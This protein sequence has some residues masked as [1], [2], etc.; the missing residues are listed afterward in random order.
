MNPKSKPPRSKRSKLKCEVL[1]STSAF[2]FNL[3]RYNVA[4]SGGGGRRGLLFGDAKVGRCR[5][6]LS[7]PR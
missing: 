2:N 4:E 1:L 7:N 6:T 5:L 3:R